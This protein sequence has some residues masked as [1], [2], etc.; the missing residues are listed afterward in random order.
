MP[1]ASVSR[2]R[3]VPVLARSV[4]LGPVFPPAQWGLGHRAIQGE[5][6]P[7]NALQL[8]VTQ[9]PRDPELLEHPGPGPLGKA[10]VGAGVL[11]DARAIQ[12]LPRAAGAQHKQ[13]AVHRIPVRYAGT[14]AAQGM[15]FA[16]RQQRF[17]RLPQF[18]GKAPMI[19]FND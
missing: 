12:G 10:A 11:A 4:G 2:L 9:Q 19:I 14:V 3:L 17:H 15:G 1:L 6:L 16:L 7:V 8:F 5:P 18:V 13:Y